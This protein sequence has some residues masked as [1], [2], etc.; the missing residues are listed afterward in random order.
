MNSEFVWDWTFLQQWWNQCS[1]CFPFISVNT[2]SND[3]FCDLLTNV[4]LFHCFIIVIRAK[5]Y[6]L[7]IIHSQ[8]IAP[9]LVHSRYPESIY[10]KWAN[11]QMNVFPVERKTLGHRRHSLG[12]KYPTCLHSWGTHKTPEL[13]VTLIQIFGGHSW[14]FK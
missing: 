7:F 13:S 11:Q 8:Y 2:D 6:L 14:V 12:S 9:G 5:I 1:L 4:C 3:L 10:I